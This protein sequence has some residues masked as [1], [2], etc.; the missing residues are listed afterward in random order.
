[1]NSLLH[2]EALRGIRYGQGLGVQSVVVDYYHKT[3]SSYSPS[4]SAATNTEVLA[5]VKAQVEDS[6]ILRFLTIVTDSMAERFSQLVSVS[7]E[8]CKISQADCSVAYDVALFTPTTG[9]RLVW[10]SSTVRMTGEAY[11]EYRVEKVFPRYV[12]DRALSFVLGLQDA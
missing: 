4:T 1:M 12:Q 9:D 7:A 6:R 11:K 10:R 2:G 3:T 8:D 5:V